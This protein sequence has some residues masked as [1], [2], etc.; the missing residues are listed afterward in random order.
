MSLSSIFPL[1]PL[2]NSSF[3]LFHLPH[4]IS[5]F[6]LFCVRLSGCFGVPSII[7]STRLFELHSL[8]LFFSFPSIRFRLIM[9]DCLCE[10]APKTKLL[11]IVCKYVCLSVVRMKPPLTRANHTLCPLPT[12]QYRRYLYKETT[13]AANISSSFIKAE[14]SNPPP[15]KNQ[16]REKQKRSYRLDFVYLT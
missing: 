8:Y 9:C 6:H 10:N 4:L 5:I 16:E 13:T 12:G 2:Y 3:R 14:K 1:P 15:K 7:I 11:F